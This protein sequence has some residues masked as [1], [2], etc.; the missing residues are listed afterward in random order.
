ML[1]VGQ[2]STLEE[3]SEVQYIAQVFSISERIRFL[4]RQQRKK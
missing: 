1:I 2:I 3:N 4:A